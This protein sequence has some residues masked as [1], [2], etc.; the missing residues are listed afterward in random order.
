MVGSA[1]RARQPAL[2]PFSSSVLQPLYAMYCTPPAHLFS[3]TPPT[4]TFSPPPPPA[5]PPPLHPTYLGGARPTPTAP[6]ARPPARLFS[7]LPCLCPATHTLPHATHTSRL[8][9]LLGA[10]LAGCAHL[11]TG[12]AG[13]ALDAT[14][15]TRH[16]ACRWFD[17]T[18][19]WLSSRLP[20]C[21]FHAH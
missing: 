4:T 10:T 6:A 14:E 2:I 11:R 12:P 8:H 19:T 21:L 17:T 13:Q 3:H 1:W 15:G 16:F 9:Q 18:W 5:L 7:L 20:S